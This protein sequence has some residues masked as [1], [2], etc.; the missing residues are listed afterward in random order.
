MEIFGK[1]Q[2]PIMGINLNGQELLSPRKI[3]NKNIH[4]PKQYSVM[5]MVGQTVC[6][7]L[8][9]QRRKN[10]STPLSSTQSNTGAPQTSDTLP[11]GGS[12]DVQREQEKT[13]PFKVD[14]RTKNWRVSKTSRKRAIQAE[15]HHMESHRGMR[16]LACCHHCNP[17]TAET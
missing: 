9:T 3:K 11:G 17:G 14:Y 7:A 12:S 6:S 2:N 5:P 13:T 15:K 16:R 8:E 1:A 10:Q 4:S